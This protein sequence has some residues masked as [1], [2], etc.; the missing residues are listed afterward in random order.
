MNFLIIAPRYI[1]RDGQYYEFP[2]GL[3]YLSAVLKQ[4]GYKVSCLNLNHYPADSLPGIVRRTI[5]EQAIDVVCTGGLS[6]HYQQLRILLS[7]VHSISSDLLTIVGGGIVSSEPEL[8]LEA[9]GFDIGVI[10]EGEETIVELAEALTAGRDL[11]AIQGLVFRDR[12]GTV[13][14]TPSRPAIAD[15]DSLP[16]PDYEGFD[17]RH[18][19]KLQRP[20]DN[21]YLYPFDNPRILPLI[22]SR[23]CPFNCTFCFHPL[24]NSYRQRSLDSFFKEVEHL[25]STYR[26]NMLAI[27]DELFSFDEERL[28]K[29]CQRMEGF[30]LKWLAQMRVDRI[31]A[32]TLHLLKRSGLFCISYG[33]ESASPTILKSM[34]KHIT[35]EQIEN[36]LA[37]TREADI[38]IQGNFLFGDPAETWET[39]TETLSWWK[40]HSHYQINLTPII[41]Y[42]GCQDYHYCREKSLIADPL[43]FIE[44][45]CP[46]LNMTG[47]D[48]PTYIAMF[49]NIFQT[50]YENRIHGTVLSATPTGYDP[51]KT[52]PVYTLKTRCPHCEQVNTYRNFHKE[53]L[54][55]FKVAC[56]H[57]NQRYDISSLAFAHIRDR[58]DGMRATII[59]AA[60]T[61]RAI[62][63]TPY[64]P[65]Y[66]FYQTME[67]LSLD[68]HTANIACILDQD[69]VKIGQHYLSRF[70]VHLR[71][72][73]T[74]RE[75]CQ[76]HLFMV[77]PCQRQEAIVD[78]LRKECQVAE[79]DIVPISLSPRS[80]DAP[81]L[82]ETLGPSNH[83]SG[84]YSPRPPQAAPCGK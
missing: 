74:V 50:T 7:W 3:G 12:E 41:P 6:P 30:N 68:W 14:R 21:Y 18:Y 77:L 53:Q 70:P 16:L 4:Q 63:I 45:G 47:M 1:E 31:S 2:L 65:E 81:T 17:V 32:D 59:E 28:H 38:G 80:E 10:G 11:E 46:L 39:A 62:S 55:L 33:L 75:R 22:S 26:I 13:V 66:L 42:P 58:A 8:M 79:K 54:E 69:Q 57:C 23:S 27:L 15:L 56:R 73:N 60:L 51:L 71:S 35:L 52:S 5:L 84:R 20:S 72:L 76:G 44:S 49:H 82:T 43:A 61:G 67:L 29:F 25:V 19:L 48:Q 37:L 40:R 9:L 83:D 64:L 36:A 24:G 34:K 78:H